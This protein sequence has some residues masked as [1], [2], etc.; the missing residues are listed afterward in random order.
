M[1]KQAVLDDRQILAE[2]AVK[3]WENNDVVELE[4]EFEGF[5]TSEDSACF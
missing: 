4:K 1:I 3:I 2:M 5:I